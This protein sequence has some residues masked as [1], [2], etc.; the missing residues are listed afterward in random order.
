MP[1]APVA[2]A[3]FGRAQRSVR[4]ISLVWISGAPDLAV[5]RRDVLR[6]DVVSARD[7]PLSSL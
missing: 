5:R 1:R 4:V 6:R 7:V 2:Y 3:D